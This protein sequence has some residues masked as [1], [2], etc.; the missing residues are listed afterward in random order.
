MN[1]L[2]ALFMTSLIH[3]IP[4]P[5]EAIPGEGYFLFNEQTSIFFNSQALP[6]A[7]DA[8]AYFNETIEPSTGIIL[9]T[10]KTRPASN[11][12]IFSFDGSL[13]AEGY[14]LR[15]TKDF[16]EI[17]A[18][19]GAG[20][21]YGVQTLLQLFPP[22]VYQP[23]YQP[24]QYLPVNQ[25][26]LPCVSIKDYPRFSY[27]GMMLDVSRQFYAVE[28][29]KRF[30]DWMAKHKLNRFH[31]HLSDDNGWR[32]EIKKHPYL[33]EKEPGVARDRSCPR[34]TAMQDRSTADTTPSRKYVILWPMLPPV[35]L[36]SSRRLTFGHSK[37]AIAS[38]PDIL[39]DLT[40]EVELSIQGTSNNVWCASYEK[41]YEML[42]DIV[43]E[44]AALF[45]SRYFHIGGTKW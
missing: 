42:D 25:M 20:Y 39:C 6:L 2:L 38:Y 36:R 45:P 27:R 4:A 31:W 43:R 10:S 16:T 22:A 15:V 35:I 5:V 41:N 18:G 14:T 26:R 30:I 34:L 33:T 11:V 17:A 37:A 21:F 9:K 28:Y 19:D 8:A 7:R 32:V 1:T 40:E 3:L 23:V 44:M 24:D 12:I 29:V 13:P